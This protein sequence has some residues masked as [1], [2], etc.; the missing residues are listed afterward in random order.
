MINQTN[1]LYK[2][3]KERLDNE[4]DIIINMK[5]PSYFLVVS[6]FIKWAKDNDIPVGPGRG[7]GAGSLVAYALKITHVDPLQFGLLFERFLKS[8][9]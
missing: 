4:I 6:D 7:S 3:Y 8:R 1:K 5:F 9:T 2:K